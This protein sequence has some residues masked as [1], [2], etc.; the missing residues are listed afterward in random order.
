MGSI[1]AQ[2]ASRLMQGL[3]SQVAGLAVAL[4]MVQ[5]SAARRAQSSSAATMR[6]AA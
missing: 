6:D 2:R 1:P 3:V 4:V 5:H